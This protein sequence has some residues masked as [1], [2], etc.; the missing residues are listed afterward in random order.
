MAPSCAS[1]SLVETI[2]WCAPCGSTHSTFSV[3]SL[4]L[5][6]VAHETT[7][8]AIHS[9]NVMLK[10]RVTE[11]EQMLRQQELNSKKQNDR[12]T[13]MMKQH[14]ALES[15]LMVQVSTLNR[16]EVLIKLTCAFVSVA[17]KWFFLNKNGSV[18]Y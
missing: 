2:A 9:E 1:T 4:V 12:I 10:G 18:Y 8:S 6:Q 16:T 11:L 5:S 3:C 13:A 17:Q 7:A 14:F 15:Q